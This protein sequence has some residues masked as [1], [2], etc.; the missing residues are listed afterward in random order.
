MQESESVR[1]WDAADRNKGRMLKSQFR[2]R[3]RILQLI[4]FG[5][6]LLCVGT[7]IGLN[8]NLKCSSVTEN[9]DYTSSHRQ[10]NGAGAFDLR[11]SINVS[12]DIDGRKID[13]SN[14]MHRT[15]D[16]HGF[17][18]ADADAGAAAAGVAGKT[19]REDA[20]KRNQSNDSFDDLQALVVASLTA[21]QND[22]YANIIVAPSPLSTEQQNDA[23]IDNNELHLNITQHPNS[24]DRFQRQITRHRMY[25][26][27]NANIIDALLKDMAEQRIVH[28]V[29]MDGGTQLKLIITYENGMKAIFKPMRFSREYQTPP[30]HFY[31][32]DF[33]R[34]TAEIAAFHLDRAL[35][36]RRCVPVT[37]RRLNITTEIF[38]V[39]D[40]ALM[41]TAF[42]SPGKNLCFHGKCKC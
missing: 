2:M 10:I 24:L 40:S 7:F 8:L 15:I 33:E 30:N 18:N 5:F 23:A 38:D 6:G 29:Q 11:S 16:G 14:S 34:H 12:R 22:K 37:G 42:V 32:N 27:Q 41:R 25:S 20:L 3:F 9:S 39:A 35:G 13:S 17:S 21:T 19:Q 1:E 4:L 31:F 26:E 36:F 28:V